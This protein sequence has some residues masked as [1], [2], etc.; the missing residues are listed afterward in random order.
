MNMDSGVIVAATHHI[1][2][3]L[4]W[5]WV[6]YKAHNDLPVAFFDLGLTDKAKEWCKKRGQLISLNVPDSLVFGKDKVDPLLAAKWE[7]VIGSGV[8]DVRLKWFK[9]PFV[10]TESPFSK[11]IWIDLDCEVKTS[12]RPLLSFAENETG[13]CLGKEPEAFQKGCQSLGLAFPEEVTYNSGVVIYKK[14]APILN[15]WKEEVLTRNNLYIGDQEALSRILFLEKPSFTE[16]PP[17]YNWD[18][19]L[20]PNPN[21]LIFHWHGQKGKQMILEQIKALTSLGLTDFQELL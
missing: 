3:L 12:L 17:E 20:G 5:W 18:R 9:K 6:N 13:I 10:F 19:G 15:R 11:T 7:K 16:L 2:W 21:A 14:G 1:E 4:P 8:W